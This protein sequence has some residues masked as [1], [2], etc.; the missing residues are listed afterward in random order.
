MSDRSPLPPPQVFRA[1]W[2]F[3]VHADPIENG[4]VEVQGAEIREVRRV[5][6]QEHAVHDLG[7]A[8]IIPGLVNA[9]VHLEFSSLEKPLE[10]PSPFADWIRSV[11]AWRRTRINPMAD[12]VSAGLRESADAGVT[13]V[14]EIATPGWSTD[15]FGTA[16]PR[17][18]LFRESIALDESAVEAEL[19]A[20]ADYR[21]QFVE[22]ASDA[23]V[24]IGFSPHA[25]YSVH[26]RL[27]R[28]LVAMA[29]DS[30]APLA[31]HLAETQDELQAIRSGDGPIVDSFRASGFWRAGV[32]PEGTRPLDY[33]QAM[34]ELAHALVIHG[35]YLDD[36]EID[37]L[38][39]CPG[40]TVVYCPRTHAFFG[41][42]LH[43]WLRLLERGVRVALGTD[44]RCSNPDLSLWAEMLFLCERFPEVDPGLIL[45]LG[46][47]SGAEALGLS[48]QVGSLTAGHRAD[49]A[50]VQLAAVDESDPYRRLLHPGSRVVATMRDGCW[51]SGSPAMREQDAR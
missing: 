28:E 12:A 48:D 35:N 38:A 13:T 4:V 22:S 32:I 21:R 25:P 31:F 14:G 23:H 50:V 11:V 51:I 16:T 3:P 34:A 42:P 44:G 30:G 19:E 46:T 39:G 15:V 41:H 37:F 6:T 43:P 2:V 26:P 45:R 27:F 18:V 9:H 5:R 40:M 29:A 47:L 10:P 1:R 33:L 24:R 8:A 49:L 36:E 17:G 7:D 20:A